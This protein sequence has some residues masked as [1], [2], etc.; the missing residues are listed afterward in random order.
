MKNYAIISLITILSFAKLSFGQAQTGERP[1]GSISGQVFD[2]SSKQPI[3]YANIVLFNTTDSAQVTGTVSDKEGQFTIRNVRPGNYYLNVQFIG[4]EKYTINKIV[5]SRNQPDVTLETILL[6][7]S[8]INLD[9]VVVEGTRTPVAFRIDKKVIDVDQMPIAVSGNATD[10]LENVPSVTVDIDGNVGLRGSSNFTVLIDGR[11]SVI[12]AQDA[13]QQIPASSIKSIEIV[14]NPSAKYDPEGTAGIINVILKKEQNLGISGIANANAGGKDRY[15]GDFLFEYKTTGIRYNLGLDY[16]ERMFPGTSTERRTT[17][18]NNN[19]NYLSSSGT[20]ER[21][22]ESYGFRGGLDFNF[23][24]N[25]FLGFN[26]RYGSRSMMNNSHLDYLSWSDLNPEQVNYKSNNKGER[27]GTFITASTNYTHKFSLPGHELSAELDL[28][29]DNSDELSLTSEAQNST[30]VSGKKTIEA[31]PSTELEGKIDYTLPIGT[32]AK[33]EAGTQ[34]EFEDSE[35]INELYE[36]DPTRGSY[37]FREQFSNMTDYKVSE[38]ALYSLYSNEFGNFGIQGGFRGEYTYRTIE[39]KKTNQNFS[40]D[41]WDYFPTLHGSYKFSPVT[42]LMLSYTRRIERPRNWELEPFD[43]W[44]DA[45]N[46]RRGN[47]ALLPQFIDSYEM[48]F[49][50]LLGEISLSSEI[51]YRFTKNKIEHVRSVYAEDV[52]LNSVQ[53]IGQD[54]SFGS[55]F[56]F[57]VD[58]LPFWNVNLMGNLYQYKVEGWLNEEDFSR[59]S[60]NWNSRFNNIIKIGKSTQLQFNIMYNSPSVSSQGRSE[61][62]FVVNGAVKQ[63]FLNRKI[64]LTLQVRDLFDTGKHE[65]T[66]Q[67]ANFYNYSYRTHQAPMVMLNV[68]F[69]FNNYKNDK[70]RRNGED[71]MD[72]GGGEEY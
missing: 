38:L 15:G 7:S 28:S 58:L 50:T 21:G 53:N 43:T 46:V 71:S 16:N 8:A 72:E 51:Y 5:L 56:M 30:Q 66:S 69:N 40:I 10:I 12:S 26:L 18:F 70:N 14:T 37:L 35:E 36:Y 47:P 48:G 1:A 44:M 22:R 4:Y 57:I 23:S 32:T 67:G 49:Q 59:N 62:F 39:L 13:L 68:R 64:S 61:E 6:K 27:S 31:G 52:T 34:G 29:R 54:Y 65:S 11:P 42:Q 9:N 19:T 55:E 24:P 25:D 33:F 45:N 60:F 3:E 2:S 20:G 41:R 17:M 63:D